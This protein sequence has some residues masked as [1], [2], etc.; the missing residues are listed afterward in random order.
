MHTHI[1][2]LA[3]LDSAIPG[4]TKR[5]GFINGDNLHRSVFWV[6]GF[7]RLPQIGELSDLA[8]KDSEL[9]LEEVKQVVE[10]SKKEETLKMKLRS[11]LLLVLLALVFCS[12]MK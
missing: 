9:D 5:A 8:E 4:E 1:E 10:M 11:L 12:Q 7:H 2:K 3:Q 6:S